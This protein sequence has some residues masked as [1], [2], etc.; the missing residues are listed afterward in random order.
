MIGG[1]NTRREWTLRPRKV[2]VSRFRDWA[3]KSLKPEDEVVVEATSN[4][5]DINDIVVPLVRK[6][7]VPT[8]TKSGRSP[9]LE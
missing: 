9:R 8:H 6:T 3:E 2:Q 1:Q 7:V 4:V 5:W